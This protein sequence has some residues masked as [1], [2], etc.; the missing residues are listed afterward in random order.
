MTLIRGIRCPRCGGNHAR[1]LESRAGDGYMR[2]RHLCLNPDCAMVQTVRHVAGRDLVV[3][4]V[5]WTSYQFFSPR[6]GAVNVPRD[7]RAIR[8][9]RA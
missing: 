8:S 3:L 6:R 4:G 1:V 5:R 9:V 2:R 7:T